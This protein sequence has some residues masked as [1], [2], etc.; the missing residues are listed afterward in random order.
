M[1]SIISIISILNCNC[2]DLKTE[3][4]TLDQIND[5]VLKASKPFWTE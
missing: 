1:T 3:G 2:M 4:M 5:E